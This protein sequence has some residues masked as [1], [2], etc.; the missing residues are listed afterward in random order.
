MENKYMM[1]KERTVFLTLLLQQLGSIIIW[2]RMLAKSMN[3]KNIK[4]SITLS[5]N[6]VLTYTLTGTRHLFL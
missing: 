4:P 3:S 1:P 6:S 2:S 5:Y